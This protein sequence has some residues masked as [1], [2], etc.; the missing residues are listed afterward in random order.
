MT[1][2]SVKWL[3]CAENFKAELVIGNQGLLLVL[4]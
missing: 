2:A 4:A 3:N 1:W